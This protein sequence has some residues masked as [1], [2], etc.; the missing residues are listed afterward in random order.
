[1]NEISTTGSARVTQYLEGQG[2]AFR[3]IEHPRTTSAFADARA[4]HHRPESVAKTIVLREGSGYVVAVIP[5]S[6]RLDLKKLRELTGG[7]RRLQLVAESEMSEE[8][9]TFEVGATPPFGTDLPGAEVVDSRLLDEDRVICAS[10]DHAHSVLIDPRDLVAIAG[11]RVGDIC[12][13]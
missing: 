3:L 8:F 9:P 7:S 2:I 13:D 11:A 5:A 10:G 1:M 12:Q 6:E 4:T